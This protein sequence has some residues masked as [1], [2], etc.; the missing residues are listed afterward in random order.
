MV[1]L[2]GLKWAAARTLFL[3]AA[4]GAMFSGGLLVFVAAPLY[5]WYF[6]NDL[7]FWK[8]LRFVYPAFSWA[9]R[10]AGE[11]L[12]SPYYRRVSKFKV[13]D[14]PRLTPDL[15]LVR[16]R[17]SWPEENG[18]CGDCDNCCSLRN[19]PLLDTERHQC[20][21]YGSFFWRYFNCG[22]YPWIP[23]Q[24]RYYKCEKWEITEGAES[25]NVEPI[26][27]HSSRKSEDSDRNSSFRPS[28]RA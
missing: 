12:R 2:H 13:S 26:L 25:T 8:Y 1:S 4:V 18:A 22:R 19:C 24:I 9:W 16:L 14:P 21:G 17:D 10:M 23:E 5:S 7:K 15:S 27:D 20:R 3:I 6:F 28:H 11:C